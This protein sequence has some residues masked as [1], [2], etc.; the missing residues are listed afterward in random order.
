MYPTS[1]ISSHDVTTA[2]LPR[3]GR[4]SLHLCASM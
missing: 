2:Y 1:S 4:S 3:A